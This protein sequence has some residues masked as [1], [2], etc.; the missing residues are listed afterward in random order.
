LPAGLEVTRSVVQRHG[1]GDWLRTVVGDLLEADFGA[2]HQ[3]ANIGHIL[4]SEG[5]ER[6]RRLLRKT[7]AVVASGGTIVISEFLPN[8]ERTGPPTPLIFAVNMLL[9]GESPTADSPCPAG[10]VLPAHLRTRP[11]WASLKSLYI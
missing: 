3:V 6:S 7:F 8:D 11:D 9:P 10:I 4:H 2:G 1:V 5:R